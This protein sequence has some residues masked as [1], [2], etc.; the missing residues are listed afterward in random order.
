MNIF[1]T[2]VIENVGDNWFIA[3]LGVD[4]DGKH[5]ILT[6]DYVH[7]S[8]LGLFSGGPKFDGELI[9]HLLN[10]YYEERLSELK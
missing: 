8:E 10:N 5:Y 1:K 9:C 3:D 4:Q 7:A 2:D 6:T